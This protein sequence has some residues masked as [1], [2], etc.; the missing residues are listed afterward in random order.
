LWPVA[1]IVVVIAAAGALLW[2]VYRSHQ[3]SDLSTFG[4]FAVAVIV[5]VASLVVYLSKLRRPGVTRPL[6]ELADSLAVAVGEQWTHA[7]LERRLLEPEPIPVQ[8]KR[9]SRPLA[10]PVAA[11][12]ESRQ[13]PPLPGLSRTVPRQLRSGQLQDLHAVYG[14]LGSGRLVIVGE[15][16]SG[17]TGAAVLLILAALEYRQQVPSQDRQLVPVPVMFTLHGWDPNTKR[18]TDWLAARLQE[19]Y[20]LFAGKGGKA[21]GAELVKAGRIAVILDGLDEIAEELR[22]VALRALSQQAALRVVVLARSYEMTA[23]ARQGFLEGAAALELE[24]VDTAAAADY[25]MRVQLDPPPRGWSELTGRLRREPGS[26]IA[27]ALSN[28]LTLTLVRDTYRSGDDIREL[29]N[30]CDAVGDVS[31]EDIQDYLLDRVLPTAYTP[32]P[33]EPPPKYG[34]SEAEIALGCIAVR[35]SRDGTRD[36]AWWRIPA[37]APVAPRVIATAVMFGLLFWFGGSLKLGLVV[38]PIAALAYLIGTR[39][40]SPRRRAPL[41]WRQ[42]FTRSSL[43]VGLESALAGGLFGGLVFGLA[44]GPT[45]GRTVGLV[46]AIATGLAGTLAAGLSQPATGDTSPLTPPA[47]WRSDQ[48]FGLIVGLVLGASIGLS[49]GFIAA[50]GHSH[51]L[52]LGLVYGL[53]D[54]VVFGVVWGLSYPLTWTASL[55]FAQLAVSWHTPARLLRFLEDARQR[56]VLRTVG[57]IY[58]FRHARLQDRLARQVAPK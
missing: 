48:G 32:R 25:L 1:A 39:G 51:E 52:E 34:L 18:V 20:P 11:A 8:W 3:R 15:P 21:E 5:A 4:A 19:T 36:L 29:L 41:R 26:P 58:Q 46:A 10:G 27:K 44:F 14:G 23:A 9:S 37:W 42:L 6:S 43:A 2:A 49:L 40:K 35:M 30:F 24:A 12:V 55:A 53:I 28:P 54:G 17:K 7:A 57:P 33:G 16:G 38:T 56:D 22:P 31:G 13:F 47:S 45:A 50:A